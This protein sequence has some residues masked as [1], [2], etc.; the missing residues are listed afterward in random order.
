MP[1][2]VLEWSREF[3]KNQK[4]WSQGEITFSFRYPAGPIFF[5]FVFFTAG[6]EG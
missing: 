4:K 5:S 2:I 1:Y 3:Q 6:A